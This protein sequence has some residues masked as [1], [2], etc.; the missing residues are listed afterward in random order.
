MKTPS[1]VENFVKI[2]IVDLSKHYGGASSRVLSLLRYLPPDQVGFVGLKNSP[3]SEAAK[4]LSL[5]VHCISSSKANP[6]ILPRLI[7]IIEEGGY[8]VIDTHNIQSK[9]WGSLAARITGKALISTLHSWYANEHKSD[10]WRGRFYTKLEKYTNSGLNLY[11]TVSKTIQEALI[12]S[13]FPPSKAKLIHNAV[14]IDPVATPR[15]DKE[16]EAQFG[17]PNDS[18][19]FTAVG[20]LVPVKGYNHL[21][22]AFQE[23]AT[24]RSDLYCIIVG[25]GELYEELNEKIY[26]MKLQNRIHLLGHCDHNTV[27]SIL[28]SSDIFLMPSRS[29]GTPIALLEAAALGKAII[30]SEVGGIPELVTNGEHA[31]LIPPADHQAL[32]HAMMKFANNK[33][34]REEYGKRAQE[35]VQKKFALDAMINSTYTAYIRAR[36]LHQA[37]KNTFT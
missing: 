6:M 14:F 27:L 23:V 37:Q 9:F 20:R 31:I 11:I 21:I 12:E 3:V 32:T 18:I 25:D 22:N 16:L 26:K 15:Y 28:K 10:S 4:K 5:P 7:K 34:I 13:D 19:I 8:Q 1:S 29:E 33:K 17:I 2:L 36:N 35:R 30:A 24:Q